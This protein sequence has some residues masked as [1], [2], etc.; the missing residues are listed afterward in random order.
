MLY[1]WMLQY[2]DV[3][4][5]GCCNMWMLQ[6]VDVVYWVISSCYLGIVKQTHLC[7]DEMAVPTIMIVVII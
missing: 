5:C 6:Y 2:V 7:Y 1:M 4:I 3:A